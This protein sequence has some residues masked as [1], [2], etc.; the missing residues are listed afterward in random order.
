MNLAVEISFEKTG[1]GE[2]VVVNS[3]RQ[4][5]DEARRATAPADGLSLSLGKLAASLGVVA[6]AVKGVSVLKD[7]VTDGLAFNA[8]MEASRLGIAALIGAFGQVKDASGKAYNDLTTRLE[9][10]GEL[11]RQLKV[12]ALQTT[13]TYEEMV[14][15]LQVGLGPALKAGFNTEQ[16]VAFTKM[17]TQSA[18]AIGLPMN[19]LGQEIRALF[20][21][22][23]GPDSRLANL[24]FTDIPRNKI[25][26]YV[27]E[28]Q[29]SGKFFDEL[30]SRMSSF[31]EAGAR[32]GDTMAGAWSNLKDAFQQALG[33]GTQG[34]FGTAT[35][36]VK[37]LTAQI[38]TFDAKGRA[39]FNQDFVDGVGSVAKAFVSMASVVVDAISLIGEALDRLEAT[40]KTY[41]TIDAWV[42]WGAQS[43]DTN[44]EA[45]WQKHFA[46]AQRQ[47]QMRQQ[48]R[49]NRTDSDRILEELASGASSGSVYGLTDEMRRRGLQLSGNGAGGGETDEQ[50]RARETAAKKI[51]EERQKEHDLLTKITAETQK[52]IDLGLLRVNVAKAATEEARNLAEYT[53]KTREI[54]LRERDAVNQVSGMKYTSEL[55]KIATIAQIRQKFQTEYQEA[56]AVYD[57]KR[58]NI[59][60]ANHEALVKDAYELLE[61]Q[62]KAAEELGEYEQKVAREVLAKKRESYER[63][64]RSVGDG[65]KNAM[66]SALDG[67]GLRGVFDSFFKSVFDTVG[68]NFAKVI[69][70][71]MEKLSLAAS[72]QEKYRSGTDQ[73][74]QPIFSYR[75][76]KGGP[77]RGAQ[78][79]MAGL[80]AASAAYGLYSNP[81]PKRSQNMLSG[82]ISGASIG[83]SIPGVS[84]W[85]AV[86]GAVVGAIVGAF[87][88]TEKGKNIKIGG[89]AAGVS[90]SGM[91][92]GWGTDK[93]LKS[94]NS[95]I[96]GTAAKLDDIFLSLPIA[97]ISAL[98]NWRPDLSKI[99]TSGKADGKNW[100]EELDAYLKETLPSRVFGAYNGVIAG[101]LKFAGVTDKR[102]SDFTAYL[103]TLST[104][105]A[106]KAVGDYLGTIYGFINLFDRYFGGAPVPGGGKHR[107]AGPMFDAGAKFEQ[108][109]Y[110]RAD[111]G[112]LGEF[113]D[114]YGELKVR[115]ADYDTASTQ[116]DQI[117][118]AKIIND[119]SSQF[120]QGMEQY[121]LHLRDMQKDMNASIDDT[122][123]G[124]DYDQLT[125]PKARVEFLQAEQRRL[126]SDLA[127]AS[128]AEEVNRI[129]QQMTQN[130]SK[131]YE[132]LGK[133]PDAAN[134]YKQQL[135]D[136]RTIANDRYK[137]FHENAQKM[138]DDTYTLVHDVLLKLQTGIEATFPVP[139]P[140]PTGGNPNGDPPGGGRDQ[141]TNA[142]NDSTAKLLEF[143]PSISDATSRLIAF[144][145]ALEAPPVINVT[146]VMD[147]PQVNVDIDGNIQPLVASVTSK[148]TN[149]A[150]RQIVTAQARY[151]QRSAMTGR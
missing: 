72:G 102:L 130:G 120:F 142:L 109:I 135:E 48:S 52:G 66:A 29:T 68:E 63:F 39:V 45:T 61:E 71:W 100:N 112:P 53:L 126:Y 103:K 5:G 83:L 106:I 18:A 6:G 16:V 24:L 131:I 44:T 26:A 57:E 19:Q 82:A 79:G 28:L 54:E 59:A 97:A 104:D 69:D 108:T 80:Q 33:E 46:D 40:K 25:K 116:E 136:A 81:A 114:L 99:S 34:Q 35:Q 85:A 139:A 90:I 113:G 14:S 23:I 122:I 110:A 115:K 141:N 65:L 11:Q 138:I 43:G 144:S 87:A 105:E 148:A 42:P 9:V 94:I 86:V 145:A 12:A 118:R 151:S 129:M 31:A 134:L 4:I 7:L 92:P 49:A 58:T 27:N 78:Y 51:V 64:Y 93:L 121:L 101:A 13:A 32:A 89:T 149:A 98:G 62:M 47:R 56:E 123:R 55:Q 10:A 75:D 107:A 2:Q 111:R 143:S 60:E 88:P 17:V 128:S 50:R 96:R 37:D 73:N 15:A 150:V 137:I 36:L 132:L 8:Q 124:I 117:A 41:L 67:G 3:I 30:Q 20:A 84:P 119:L 125:D 70:G 21:G 95:S 133:T 127:N 22:D 38:V 91:D 146:V 76:R 1:K 147:A 74:G 77:S 140:G